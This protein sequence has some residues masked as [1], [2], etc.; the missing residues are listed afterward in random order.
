VHH[1][2]AEQLLR[3]L[4]YQCK[5]TALPQLALVFATP[6]PPGVGALPRRPKA[7]SDSGMM[8]AQ[9]APQRLKPIKLGEI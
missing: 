8:Q 2:I 5:R 4:G 9:R 1:R 3:A 7:G 6:P